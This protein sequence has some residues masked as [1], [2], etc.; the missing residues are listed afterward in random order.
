MIGNTTRRN[1]LTGAVALAAVSASGIAI[2]ATA[3]SPI[4]RLW[5][6]AEAIKSRLAS[7][8][9]PFAVVGAHELVGQRFEALGQ[10]LRSR[11]VSQRD[12][13]ILE[14]ASADGDIRHRLA[15]WANIRVANA[16]NTMRSAALA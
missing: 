8:Q 13:A 2:N 9:A 6:Q 4:E 14:Q 11:P 7:L 10:I 5:A 12:R 3:S 16:G 15:G 1:I